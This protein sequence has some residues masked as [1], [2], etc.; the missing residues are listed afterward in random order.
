MS[1]EAPSIR[2]FQDLERKVL[3]HHE[4]L[5]ELERAKPKPDSLLGKIVSWRNEGG[6]VTVAIR[7]PGEDMPFYCSESVYIERLKR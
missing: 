1:I 4:R 6:T 2:Q 7:C 5:R 3:K